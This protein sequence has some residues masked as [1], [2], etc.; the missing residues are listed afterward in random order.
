MSQ[1]STVPLG[2]VRIKINTAII[3]KCFWLP[4]ISC[5][6]L[7]NDSQTTCNDVK[8]FCYSDI[9]EHLLSSAFQ[10]HI[11]KLRSL[12]FLSLC[13]HQSD[14]FSKRSQNKC[15][16]TQQELCAYVCV[17]VCVCVWLWADLRG[18]VSRGC[19]SLLVM[20]V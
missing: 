18:R 6:L 12:F 3:R 5:A 1:S 8:L 4:G 15:Y 13:N 2:G 9:R 10:R 19:S 16:S 20:L 7:S 11:H 17:H 14:F